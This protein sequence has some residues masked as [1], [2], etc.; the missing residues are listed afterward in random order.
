[1]VRKL[2]RSGEVDDDQYDV[3]NGSDNSRQ[4]NTGDHVQDEDGNRYERGEDSNS[5]VLLARQIIG[6]LSQ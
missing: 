3:H 2:A 1:M 5:D 4:L 6:T